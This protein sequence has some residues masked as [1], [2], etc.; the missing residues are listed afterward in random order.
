MHPVEAIGIGPGLGS[1]QLP[2]GV[3]IG[4]I[5]QLLVLFQQ[6]QGLQ[7]RQPTTAGWRHG[8]QPVVPLLPAEGL[9][10]Y[11]RI[12]AEVGSSPAAEAGLQGLQGSHPRQDPLRQS[13]VVKRG[14]TVVGQQLQAARQG[15][16]AEQLVGGRGLAAGQVERL[17]G[18]AVVHA[19]ALGDAERAAQARAGA[20]AI[21]GQAD[22]R[23]QRGGPG[24]AAVLLMGLPEQSH[25]AGHTDGLKAAG[26]LPPGQRFAGGLQQIARSAALRGDLAAIEH[27]QLL[28][29]GI[30][31]QQK[32]TA[33][34]AGAL[35]FHHRQHRL[36]GDQGIHR[37]TAGIENCQGGPAG[38]G[39]GGDHHG[40]ADGGGDGGTTGIG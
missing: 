34:Q 14:A 30:P 21:A 6:R 32:T 29:P 35:G 4:C 38:A 37:G 28:L 11:H 31:V 13:P 1:R 15:R 5:G 18:G 2:P 27:F 25:G 26:G 17:E 22:G 19:D 7:H 20:E 8:A 39:I 24:Q 23:F 36:G 12:G 16:V 10:A 9:A 3:G 40:R 33:R